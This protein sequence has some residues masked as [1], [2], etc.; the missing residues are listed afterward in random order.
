MPQ[1]VIDRCTV[2]DRRARA[3]RAQHRAKR[4]K[5]SKVDSLQVSLFAELQPGSLEEEEAGHQN[6][7]RGLKAEA[8]QFGLPTQLVWPRTLRLKLPW[9]AQAREHRTWRRGRGTLPR[10][11]TTKPAVAMAPCGARAWG[12]LRWRVFLS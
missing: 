11:Y 3:T 5:K 4:M 12:L 10:R 2:Q 7:R 1:E 6:L 8:M 9:L